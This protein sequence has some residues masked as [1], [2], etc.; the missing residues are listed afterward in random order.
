MY[1]LYDTDWALSNKGNQWR[2]LEGRLLV[3]GKSK[4]G[5][6]ARVGDTFVKGRFSDTAEAKSA[7]ERAV[8]MVSTPSEFGPADWEAQ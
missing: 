8:A 2:R 4:F 1:D 7:A 6:W 5:F 3:V